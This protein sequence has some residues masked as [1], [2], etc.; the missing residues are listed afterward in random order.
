MGFAQECFLASPICSMLTKKPCSVAGKIFLLLI[1]CV[2]CAAGFS[3]SI[4]QGKISLKGKEINCC[5]IDSLKLKKN[6]LAQNTNFFPQHQQLSLNNTEPLGIP[7]FTVPVVF[8]IISS[9]PSRITDQQIRDAV[10]DLN[11]AFAHSG[12]YAAG[13]P[14]A[15][16]GITF[17]LARIDPDGGISTGITR[18]Q[19]VLGDFDEDIEDDRLKSLASWD[20]KQYCNI[21]LVDSVRNE[22]FTTFSCGVWARKQ[23]D[24]YTSFLPGGDYRDGIVTTGFGSPLATL[25]GTYLG[26][27]ST[28]RMG[29]CANTNC[30]T[31]GDGVRRHAPFIGSFG[32]LYWFTKLMQY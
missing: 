17:C 2:V 31:D 30:N 3:Q 32:L 6:G 14:G 11:N 12:P 22:Y 24:G 21:W 28:F 4:S 10:Q 16:T 13:A 25:M 19:S 18:T 7:S 26:L 8:H 23:N 29:S 1:C 9:D 27:T 5:G 20:T 15:N